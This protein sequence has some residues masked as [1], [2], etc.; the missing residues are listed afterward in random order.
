MNLLFAGDLHI[1]DKAPSGRVDDYMETMLGKLESITALCKK[2]KVEH[3]FFTGDIYHVKQPNRV[4]HGLVQRLIGAFK[5]FPCP[6]YVVPGNHDY[7]PE[8]IDSLPRQPLGTLEKAGAIELLMEMKGFGVK[9]GNPEFWIVPRPYNAVAEGVHTGVT[10]PSYYALTEEE[11]EKIRG[12]KAPVIGLA[13]GSLVAPG[14][15]R[16]Y[17]TVD[18]SQIP[19]LE[20][21][22][23]L[24]SGHIH[25]SLG[26]V[27][28]GTTVFANPGSVARTRRDLASYARTIEV[29]LVGVDKD[30]VSVEEVPLPDVLPALE[31][32]GRRSPDDTVELEGVD[33]DEISNF[34][35]LLGQGIRADQM[36]IPELLAELGDLEPKVKA[37]VQRH[38]E[39]AS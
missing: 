12:Q 36:S 29:L 1:A 37:E 24:V 32:F 17:P 28:V 5:A 8:G 35:E 16:Q 19:G 15:S 10:D 21:Y 11:H 34:V 38:L 39:E 25:E 6:V 18:V 3:A 27:Q 4:S 14:D 7:G 2:H 13:H 26:V 30:G 20:D 31:V 23:L 9:D 22:N 33:A